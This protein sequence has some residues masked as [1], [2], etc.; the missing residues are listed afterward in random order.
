[1]DDQN[2]SERRQFFLGAAATLGTGALLGF[3]GPTANAA[4]DAALHGIVR[5]ALEH[6]SR[7][8]SR[9]DLSLVEAFSA[10]ALLVGSS[11][12]E[13]A[14]GRDAIRSLLTRAYAKPHVVSW[15]WAAPR[16]WQVGTLIWFFV[17]ATV[18]VTEAA[19]TDRLPYR[20][21]GVLEKQ[22]GRW[23]W[24]QYMGSEPSAA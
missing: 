6:F 8:I 18:V 22:D 7:L 14:P 9:K 24:R 15:E 12:G 4:D 16:V 1:M 19:K 2:S 20:V 10:D 13:I 23:I 5:D 11:T 21:A 3:A 17:E